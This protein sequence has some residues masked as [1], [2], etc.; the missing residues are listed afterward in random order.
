MIFEEFRTQFSSKLTK[1]EMY[2]IEEIILNDI[3]LYLRLRE[4]I[5]LNSFFNKKTHT[6][7]FL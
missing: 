1:N 7:L 3:K 6:T 5:L 2:F 4:K